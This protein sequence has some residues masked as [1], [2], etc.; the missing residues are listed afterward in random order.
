MDK[1]VGV[2]SL[3]VSLKLINNNISNIN[4]K[5]LTLKHFESGLRPEET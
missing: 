2:S 4:K 5:S 3:L 1:P